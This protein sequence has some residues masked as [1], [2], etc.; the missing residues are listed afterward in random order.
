MKKVLIANR[1]EIA[2]RIA[3]T[4][5]EAGIASVAIFADPD[6]E[7]LHV[8]VADEAYSL[9]GE[10]VADTYLNVEKI[11][12]IARRSGADAL[13]PGYGF[14]AE[15]ADVAQAVID[16][17]L[18]WIGPEPQTIELLGDKVAARKI[19]EKVGAPLVKGSDG[20][21]PDSR[22]AREVTEELGLPIAIKAAY[23][24]GGRGMRVV[25]RLQDVEEAFES[26]VRES[27]AA[28]GRGECYLEQFLEKPRHV[29]AQVIADKHGNVFVLGT[30]DC[31]LQRRNQ[32][33]VEEAPAP[34]LTAEQ[35][36]LIVN[37][38]RDICREAGYVGVGTV[39]YL[40]GASGTIS[41]LEVNTRIQVEHT[42]TEEVTGL[43][44][45]LAQLQIAAGERVPLDGDVQPTGHAFQFRIN[46][47]DVGRGFLPATGT[48]DVF[49][50]PTG[51]GIRIDTG[52]HTDSV[53]SGRYDSMLAKVIISGISRKHAIRRARRALKE[54]RIRGITTVLP[55]HR[56]ILEEE[57][58]VSDEGLGVYTTWIEQEFSDRI[59]D[60][61]DFRQAVPSQERV[62]M[63]IEIDGKNAKLGVPAAFMRALVAGGDGGALDALDGSVSGQEPGDQ[64]ELRSPMAGTVLKVVASE[65]Q[66]LEEGD[67]VVVLEA[68]KTETP[69]HAH[70]AGTLEEL[71]VSTGDRVALDDVLARIVTE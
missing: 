59:K 66:D 17:G 46:A 32:K 14:L 38:A 23:G 28:F 42:V 9:E 71:A 2:V 15:R 49:D 64:A 57:A 20:N 61:P 26:A 5:A 30:R 16:A 39:E 1:G 11:L 56:A 25:H 29:E 6:A 45:V 7:A 51:P 36:D 40:L 52:V 48:I 35:N 10:E 69:I 21:V 27:E 68:M 41:F 65:G 12:D 4:C 58:F 53:I 8:R 31:S 62:R 70:R 43:D 34:F 67:P 33:L 54:L 60:D 47:E 50:P 18:I 63:M 55:F 13:H 37:S 19:A 24:G 3:H 44:M 22:K